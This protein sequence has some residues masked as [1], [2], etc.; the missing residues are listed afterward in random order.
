M[1]LFHPGYTSIAVHR[2]DTLEQAPLRQTA[3]RIPDAVR[4]G[5][6]KE[7]QDMLD[8]GVIEPSENPWASPVVLVPKKDDTT[9]FCVDYSRLNDWTVT[10]VYPM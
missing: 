10:D 7:I 8:L 4:E 6:R 5:M 3:Y 9:R 1:F 2:V